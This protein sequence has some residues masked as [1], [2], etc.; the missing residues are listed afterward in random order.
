MNEERYPQGGVVGVLTV[1]VILH[2]S[3][4]GIRYYAYAVEKEKCACS[5]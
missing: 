2:D 5:E 4:M 3:V 1:Q